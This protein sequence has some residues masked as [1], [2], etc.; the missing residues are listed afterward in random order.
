MGISNYGPGDIV[1]F[2]EGP[3]SGIC[4]VVHSVDSR[5]E[6]LRIDFGEGLVHREGNVLREQRHSLTV[7]FHEVELL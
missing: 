5:R 1:Y 7:G 4:A 3:F 6:E 2:A